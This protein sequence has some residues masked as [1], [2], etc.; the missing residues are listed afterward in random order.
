MVT[1]SSL[2]SEER[3]SEGTVESAGSLYTGRGAGSL[4]I[5]DRTLPTSPARSMVM[6][7]CPLLGT[8]KT[9]G[10]RFTSPP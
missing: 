1:P 4:L 3:T 8:V 6:Y 9:I 10:D 7:Q 2:V 5:E